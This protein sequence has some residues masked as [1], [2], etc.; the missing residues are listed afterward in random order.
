MRELGLRAGRLLPPDFSRRVLEDARAQ[1]QRSQRNRLTVI[2]AAVCIAVVLASHW[3]L[4]SRTDRQNLEQW[5]KA[6]Q[7][8]AALEKTI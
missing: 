7:Q 2:T 6:A 8:I 1:H 3:I 5:S 4:K